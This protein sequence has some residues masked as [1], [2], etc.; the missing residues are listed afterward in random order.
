[1]NGG[2]IFTIGHSNHPIARFSE[3]LGAHGINCLADLRSVPASR[4]A[5][6]FGKKR[7]EAE[8]TERGVDYFYLGEELGGRPKGE[9]VRDYETRVLT[10]SFRAGIAKLLAAAREKTVAMMCAERDPIDCHR[11]LLVARHLSPKSEIVHVHFDGRTETHAA[12]E[13]RLLKS[14]KLH[15]GD[16][17]DSREEQLARAYR[18][19]SKAMTK[20]G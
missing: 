11:A 13:D 10:N 16:L 4:F 18:A 14:A 20:T 3:L 2:A 12:F 5:P 6:Q 17:L 7:L 8:L 9:P 1:M 19:R 15:S